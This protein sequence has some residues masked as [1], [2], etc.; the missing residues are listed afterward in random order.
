MKYSKGFLVISI[1]IA[2]LGEIIS[3]NLELNKSGYFERNGLNVIIFDD[4]YPEGRQGGITIVQ[5]GKRVA[6][7][8]DLYIQSVPG[9]WAP[10]PRLLNKKR[11]QE[12]N[13]VIVT[14][15]YPDS[16]RIKN[17]GQP[18][19][20]PDLELKYKIKIIA[21]GEN[22]RIIVDLEKPLPEDWIGKVG[23]NI[24]LFPG[25]LFG[26]TYLMDDDSGIFPIYPNTPIEV[27]EKYLPEPMAAGQKLV[28]APEDKYYRMKISNEKGD[29]QLLDSR[30]IHNNGW[31]IVRSLVPAN[32]TK[33]AIEWLVEVNTIDNWLYKPVVHTSQVGYH[34]KQTKVAIIELDKK[35]NSIKDI[36]IN[37]IQS[38][39]DYLTVLTINENN[40]QK[41]LR[42][43]Y[44]KADFTSIEEPGMYAVQYGDIVSGPFKINDDVYRTGVWQPTIDY[45]L[46]VQMCHMKVFE[47]YR[48]WHDYCHLDDALMAPENINHFDGYTHK[49]IPQGF[50]PLKHV[51]GLKK[52]GWHDAGDYDIRIESQIGTILMLTYAFEEFNIDYDQTLINQDDEI[53]E[54]HHPDGKQDILQQ[55]EHGLL[56]VLGGYNQ[57]EKLYRG[58]ITPTLRQYVMLGDAGSMTDN[59]VFTG[60]VQKEYHDFWH[61]NITNKYSR[62]FSPRESNIIEKEY[63]KNLDDRLVFLEDNASRQLYGVTGLAAASRVMNGYNDQLAKEC[64]DAAENLWKH[65]KDAKGKRVDEKKIHA[66]SELILTTDKKEYKIELIALLP[67][68]IKTIDN[69]G[70]VLGR[71]LPKVEDEEFIQKINKEI[72]T[73]KDSVIRASNENPFGIPYHP[74]IWGAGW[75]IQYF[76]VKHYFL[77]KGWPDIFTKEPLLNALNFIL[78]NHPG[79]NTASFVSNVGAKSQTVAYGINRADWSF[80]PGGV[81]SGTNLVR[82]DLPE[83][84]EWPYLWQ[85]AEYVMGGG[86][87]NFMFLVLAADNILNEE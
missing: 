12:N 70:W 7:N 77:Y 46:P 84:L 85:Q 38:S 56:N 64:I 39:G 6:A 54:I 23:F 58:I 8:G 18:Y 80:I 5:H 20:Y 14:L 59:K 19:I 87:T 36:K 72:V 25:N 55:I 48:V 13:E 66:L 49:K 82:P 75:G 83:L 15:M 2:F 21:E 76:G 28:V 4:I 73:V 33:N 27:G 45:Y 37:K 51:E 68:I 35:D 71:V 44:L 10:Y 86:A 17:T 69:T 81:I 32:V 43:S 24:E 9:Q 41:F 62:N 52:G 26:K 16:I 3:Q 63:V 11:V 22:F 67:V 78:G 47:K 57:F 29:L 50:T 40:R 53:V 31:F 79:E 1:F 30:V 61:T 65:Y 34:T 74:R 60:E 42:Y